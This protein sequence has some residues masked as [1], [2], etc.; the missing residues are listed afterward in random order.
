VSRP[1]GDVLAEA[2]SLARAGVKEILVISQDTSAYGVDLRYRTGFWGGRPVKTRL[3]ELCE[4]LAGF[5]IWVRLHYVYPYPSVDDV[6]PLMA[7]GKILPYLDVPF[8]HAS[9]RI[10]K[11]MKRPASAENT[12]ERIAGWREVCPEIVIRSTFI[13]GFP[14][15]TDEDFDQMIQFL[16]DA[17]L[18]RVG[19][20]AYSPVEGATANRIPG[21]PPENVREDRRRWLM[22]VQ[23]DISADKLAGRIDSVIEVLVDEVDEEGTI[24]R[25]KADAPE[26]D[27][28]VYLD[29]FFAAEPGDFLKVRVI[30]AD[31]HDLYA[32]PVGQG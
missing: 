21:L 2:E 16:E 28:V 19:A 17:R 29:G 23:E 1:V 27:G 15:E 25:S 7:E 24:A 5:G 9:P 4:A 8:Q 13:T 32:E 20:F 10:L 6:I 26:I 31:H 11:A 22:Q 3:K 18:D 30:D 14:G 12:L